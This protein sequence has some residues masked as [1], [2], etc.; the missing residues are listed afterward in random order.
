MK[1]EETPPPITTA[2]SPLADRLV[3]SPNH[4][5][6]KGGRGIDM[7]VLHY[8]GMP[9]GRGMTMAERAITWLAMPRSQV[10]AHYVVDEDGTITQMVAEG[11]RAW[12]AG[13]SAWAG[14]TDV[15]SCSIGI[16]I[17]YAG[18]PWDGIYPDDPAREITQHPG[19]LPYPDAQIAAVIALSDDIAR[20]HRIAPERVLAHSDIA[21]TRKS[22]PGELFPWARLHAAG[23]GHFVEPA[24]IGGGR[25]F[26]WGDAGPPIEALQAMFALYGYSITVNGVFDDQTKAVVTAFQRHFRPALVDGIADRSTIETLNMLIRSRPSAL[27][28]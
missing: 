9:A 17:A 15:N 22:D 25:F 3:A 24:P 28:A 19:L 13:L 8:T 20:R 7:I 2:D 10:S 23:V 14:E 26:Q 27:V 16:E 6:R 18:Y 5:E 12:H 21:P 1:T 11:R 4:G